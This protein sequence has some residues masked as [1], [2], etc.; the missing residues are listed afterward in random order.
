[1]VGL[2][3]IFLLEEDEEPMATETINLSTDES[4][5]ST[6]NTSPDYHHESIYPDSINK[7]IASQLEQRSNMGTK[8]VFHPPTPNT[9]LMSDNRTSVQHLEILTK[10]HRRFHNDQTTPYNFANISSLFQTRPNHHLQKIKVKETF[11]V[12]TI[13]LTQRHQHHITTFP[14]SRQWQMG[15]KIWHSIPVRN[16]MKGWQGVWSEENN[17]TRLQKKLLQIIS[18]SQLSQVTQYENAKS[19]EMLSLIAFWVDYSFF[20]PRVSQAAACASLIYT[21]NYNGH[22]PGIQR[23]SLSLFED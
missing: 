13:Y 10:I 4:D 23:H 16:A 21:V 8:T 19:E 18:T 9:S 6:P 11:S 7:L 1:M 3:P 14:L 2:T 12:R 5:Y 17:M 20:T 15:C 22:N